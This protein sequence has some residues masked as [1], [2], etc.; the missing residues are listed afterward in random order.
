MNI[1]AH[2]DALLMIVFGAFFTLL[3]FRT[4]IAFAKG[5]KIFRIC[6][7]ALIVI[8]ALL[9]FTRPSPTWARHDTDDGIASAEFPGVPTRQDSVDSVGGVSLPRVSYTYNVP[10]Q[11]ISLV[12]SRSPIV[13]PD[14]TDDQRIDAA[15]AY[16]E[17]Q[18]F[19][20]ADRQRVQCGDVQGHLLKLRH[21]QEN[22]VAVV[23][24]VMTQSNVYRALATFKSASETEEGIKRFIESFRVRDDPL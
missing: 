3:S 16:F 12:L 5:A 8:G 24:V 21:R 22:D 10:G 23:R 15:V 20:I 9:V 18:G 2:I 14:A 1:A 4:P 6:G 17:Q 11:R 19:D 13:G 7:P